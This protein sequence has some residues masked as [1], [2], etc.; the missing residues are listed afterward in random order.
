MA[1][2]HPHLSKV[3]SGN[4]CRFDGIRGY[5]LAAVG[6]AAAFALRLL[7]DPLWGERLPYV[8]FFL[9]LLVLMRFA[10][11]GPV[12]AAAVAG[13]ALGTW[14]FVALRHSFFVTNPVTRST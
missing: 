10:A 14:F 9:A 8:S 12:A 7:L 2:E 5:T 13:V 3:Y 1:T 11:P 6:V 4:D